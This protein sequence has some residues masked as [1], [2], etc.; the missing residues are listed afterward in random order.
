[1]Q[2]QY[3]VVPMTREYLEPATELFISNYKHEQE[4]SPLLP[5]RVI[6]EPEWIYHSLEARLGNFGVAVFGQNRLLAYM[7]TGAQF[8]WKGQQAV[9]VPEYCHGTVEQ[10]KR[11]LYQRMYMH[12]SQEW[13]NHHIHLQMIGHFAH[14]TILQETL[15]Q[16]GFG[17]ILAE[18]LRDCS[19]LNQPYEM[20]VQEET[21]VSK[22]L[23]IQIEHNNYY[24]KAPIFITK[25]T[26]PHEVLDELEAHARQ[27]DVFFVYY[28]Q[29]EPC[30]YMIVGNSTID[31]EGFLLQNT[32]AAQIKSAY[33]KPDIRRRGI[34][35]ALLQRAVE[36]SRAHRYER[37]FVEHETANFSGSIFWQKHF[38]PY[39]YFSMRYIDNTI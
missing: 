21:D 18:R 34:G 13:V 10:E 26:S 12:L 4:E 22:L 39:I 11:E 31:G 36:W 1:M 7:V 19:A 37:I 6:T 8:P 32:N 9:L 17:A 5:S 15:Y 23:N 25:S 33:A 27:G 38:S 28:E 35:K 3:T 20:E 24:S 30:A 2:H 29:G 16:L 14:D